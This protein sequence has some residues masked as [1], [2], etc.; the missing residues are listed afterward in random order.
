MLESSRNF[1][2]LA[3]MLSQS[4]KDVGMFGCDCRLMGGFVVGSA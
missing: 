3:Y 4:W 2:I 1:F